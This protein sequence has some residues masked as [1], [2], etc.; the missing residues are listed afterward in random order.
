MQVRSAVRLLGAPARFALIA[1]IKGYRVVLSGWLGGQCRFFPSCS[2]YAE[3]AIR[4]RGAVRGPALAI[5]RLGRC[6]PFGAGG[7]DPVP[8]G[9]SHTVYDVVTQDDDEAGRRGAAA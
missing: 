3:E 2:E 4:T 8:R 9:A 1:L 7:L 6:N 5:W